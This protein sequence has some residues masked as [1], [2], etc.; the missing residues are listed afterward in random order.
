MS[1]SPLICDDLFPYFLIPEDYNN[2]MLVSRKFRR[3]AITSITLD[4]AEFKRKFKYYAINKNIEYIDL[5]IRNNNIAGNDNH[6]FCWACE[7]G[8]LE[9]V[10]YLMNLPEKFG[11]NPSAED[12]YAIRGACENGHLETVKYLMSMPEKFGVDPSA[13]DNYAICWARVN[14]HLE[15][16]KYLMSLPEKFGVK[17]PKNE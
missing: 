5:L 6:L 15:T 2:Y 14:G 9:T 10:K 13:R 11:V 8:H 7:N 17:M 16:V 1:I 12:N 3:M 4:S